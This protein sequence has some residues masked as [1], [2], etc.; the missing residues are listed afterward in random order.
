MKTKEYTLTTGKIKT[1]HAEKEIESMLKIDKNKPSSMMINTKKGQKAI[2]ALLDL[3]LNH[4]HSWYKELKLRMRENPNA[5]ALFYRGTKITF[6]EMFDKADTVAKSL[7]KIGIEKGEEIPVCLA[8]TP[9]LVYIMLATNKIGAKLNLFSSKL[10]SEYLNEILDGCTDKLF[11][12]SDD[13]YEDIKEV[14]KERNFNNK[15]IISLTDSLP[16]YPELIYDYEPSLKEYY[17]YPNKAKEYIRIDYTLISFKE[18]SKFGNDYNELI[19]DNNDLDTEFLVTYTSGSTKI[20]LPKQVIHSNRSLIT[21][22]RFHDPELSGN[23]KLEGLRGLAHIHTDSNTDIIT[24]ISDNLMQLWSVALEPEYDKRKFLDYVIL[25]KPNYLNATKSFYIEMAKQYLIERKYHENGIGRKL[26]FLLAAF[27]VGE[28]TTKGEEKFINTFLREARAGSGV[29]IFGEISMPFTTLC[30]GGGDCEHGGIYYSLWRTMFEKLNYLKLRGREY[31]LMPESYVQASAFKK[32]QNGTFDEC[33]FNE[34]GLIAANS[35]TTMVGYK[36]A[37]QKTSDL[38][39]TDTS[40]RDWVSSNVYG[41][42]DELGGVHVKG[43]IGEEI[44]LSNGNIVPS[45]IIEE[46]ICKDTKNI[47]SCTVT[48][49]ED[50]KRTIPIINLE[51]QP[52]RRDDP[53]KIINSIIKRCDRKLDIDTTKEF[54][55]RIFDWDNPYPLTASGKR[56]IKEIEQMGLLN[57][58]FIDETKLHKKI[59]KRSK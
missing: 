46:L 3:E 4:N 49:Y 25:N 6:K 14:I 30:V 22:G 10:S 2:T 16:K 34:Y 59:K 40:G 41:Y 20:G 31:G 12:T 1:F 8:N 35:A 55:F 45:F 32:N 19:N 53:T 44:I 37:S 42:I 39:I 51:F 15:V 13:N 33:N 26:P 54:G 9:E 18:F 21:S 50:E 23:P 57:T 27:S 58:K 24:C 38:I 5:T 29:K 52:K 43:R 17:H 11:I 28:V 7:K 47:L 48:K 56:S 36:N